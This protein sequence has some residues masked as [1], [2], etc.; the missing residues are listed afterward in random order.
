MCKIQENVHIVI[1]QLL[2]VPKTVNLHCNLKLFDTFKFG[3][4]A[5]R[6]EGYLTTL[7]CVQ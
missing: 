7:N 4:G 5:L 1:L 3:P 6:S 2:L